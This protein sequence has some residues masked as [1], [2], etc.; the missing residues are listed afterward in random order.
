MMCFEIT[1]L[2]TAPSTMDAAH[3][4]ARAGRAEGTA[5]L[6][7][8]QTRG[9][10]RAGNAWF[11]A[12][13]QSLTFSV[14]LRP[15]LKPSRLGWLTMLAALAARE[16]AAEATGADATIKWFNDVLLL[17]RK[18]CGILVEASITGDA[19]DYAVLGVGLN[20]NTR[21]DDAPTDV[22]ERATSLRDA[23]GRELDREAVF[24]RLLERLGARYA[25]HDPDRSPAA[26]YARHVATLGRV[27]RVR[28]GDAVIEGRAAR[29]EDDGAL[30][31]LRDGG[32]TRV[33]FGDVV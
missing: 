28:M 27:V 4:L 29:V 7:D 11:A 5:V 9:R 22:R 17:D 6:A 31:V 19:V 14:V 10:G 26:E 25:A 13:G 3:A 21:F 20:V 2:A 30:I 16:V 12:P 1:R 15:A 24:G 18:V 33:G 8:A 32:E 23:L